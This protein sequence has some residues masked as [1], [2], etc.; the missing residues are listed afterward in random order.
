MRVRPFLAEGLSPV[1]ATRIFWPAG[2]AHTRGALVCGHRKQ[3]LHE[4]VCA[5][6]CMRAFP[7]DSKPPYARYQSG[8]FRMS[9]GCTEP[10]HTIHISPCLCALLQRCLALVSCSLCMGFLRSGALIG[11]QEERLG[12]SSGAGGDRNRSPGA[13]GEVKLLSCVSKN[14]GSSVAATLSGIL[15]WRV[16]FGDAGACN[17]C[18]VRRPRRRVSRMVP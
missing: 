11:Q 2:I 18:T 17:S 14:A 9:V 15:C 5:C 8:R 12:G 13:M 10:F 7:D 6:S 16:R 1:F 3:E 4:H